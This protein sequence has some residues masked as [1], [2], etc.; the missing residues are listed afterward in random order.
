MVEEPKLEDFE[1]VETDLTETDTKDKLH[2]VS[3]LEPSDFE[4]KLTYGAGRR[5]QSTAADDPRRV[6]GRHHPVD[7]PHGIGSPRVACAFTVE[8]YWH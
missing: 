6:L 3:T 4:F 7:S 8:S 1:F 2:Q 5:Y